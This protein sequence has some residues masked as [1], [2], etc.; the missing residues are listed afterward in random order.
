MTNETHDNFLAIFGLAPEPVVEP[1]KVTYRLYYDPEG[2]PLFYSME[3]LPG[4]YIEV[5][6]ET[7]ARASSKIRVFK[8]KIVPVT[9]ET[10][11][12]LAPSDEGTCCHP[13]NVAIVV[14]CLQPHTKWSLKS[15]G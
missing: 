11:S 6:A 10:S 8:G 12:K 13:K 1:P 15:Y 3:D 7:F 9:R 2:Q 4:N 14:D 5:D